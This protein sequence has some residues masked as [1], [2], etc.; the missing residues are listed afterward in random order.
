MAHNLAKAPSFLNYN[1]DTIL[2]HNYT[3]DEV[4]L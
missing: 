1:P 2:H 3:Y 4:Y